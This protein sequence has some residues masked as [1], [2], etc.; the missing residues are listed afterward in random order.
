MPKNINQK[1][2]GVP[3][4]NRV[5][6]YDATIIIDFL[7]RTFMPLSYFVKPEFL[8]K[9]GAS[10]KP[11]M[12]HMKDP[13]KFM[14]TFISVSKMYE[15]YQLFRNQMDYTA[16][17]ETSWK[18]GLIIK[19]L[20][21]SKNGWQFNARRSGRAQIWQAGPAV[22]RVSVPVNERSQFVVGKPT[23]QSV[24]VTPEDLNDDDGKTFTRDDVSEAATR[25]NDPTLM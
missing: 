12:N 22:L 25:L 20:L 21:Y 24:D 4:E 13:T 3:I 7:N 6:Y 23:I 17:V 15:Y 2:S 1:L 10:V 8:Q 16:P 18:F 11:Q 5:H 9:I 19:K 14:D